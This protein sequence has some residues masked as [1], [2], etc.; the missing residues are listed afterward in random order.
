MK[1]VAVNYINYSCS[2]TIYIDNL[3]SGFAT[4]LIWLLIVGFIFPYNSN[5]GWQMTHFFGINVIYDRMVDLIP[6]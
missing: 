3:Q 1:R 5:F 6:V 2:I 4:E